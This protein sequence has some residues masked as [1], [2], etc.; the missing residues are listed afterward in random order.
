MKITENEKIIHNKKMRE[1]AKKN[2][3]TVLEWD[4]DIIVGY[5]TDA[6][7][8][9]HA[10]DVMNGYGYYDDNGQYHSYRQNDD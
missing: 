6:E 10:S 2:G 4:G 9:T 1:K 5:G 7:Y 3:A 8:D